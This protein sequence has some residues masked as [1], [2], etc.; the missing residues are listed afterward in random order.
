MLQDL[1]LLLVRL[2]V[3]LVMPTVLWFL[4]S[5]LLLLLP[6]RAKHLAALAAA[7]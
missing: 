1:S 2:L 5:Q 4:L 6:A 7:Y 3:W